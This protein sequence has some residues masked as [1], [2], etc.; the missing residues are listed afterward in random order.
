MRDSQPHRKKVK[1][2]H[3]PGD[4]HEFT[5]SCHRREKL[6]AN[7]RWRQYLARAIDA[8]SA[9]DGFQL[10]AFVFMPEH[11]HLLVYPT[12]QMDDANE[13]ISRFLAAVKR[14]VSVKV[15]ADLR[16]SGSDL[17]TRLTVQERPGKNVFR[18]W[19]EGPGYDRNLQTEKS[20]SAAIDYIHQNPER[21]KLVRRLQDWR[22]SSFRWYA[23][24]GQ[25][26]DPD[27]P[28]I[29]YPPPELFR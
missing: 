12:E 1:H 5:F 9:E 25:E 16:A 19:Q 2:Y 18:F 17:L 4:L 26:I 8:A 29:H 14:P 15:K 3:E 11:V 28:E 21:R 10:I 27:L 20:V 23:S 24:Q 7:D 6:L 22:W 13:C